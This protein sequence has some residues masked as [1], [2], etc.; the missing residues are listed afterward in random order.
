M[1]G[2]KLSST[3]RAEALN[4]LARQGWAEAHGRDAIMKSYHF[5]DFAEAFAWMTR[6]AAEAEKANHHPE[7]SNTYNKVDV[8]L[9]SHD[10][11]GLTTRD[12]QLAKRF[13]EI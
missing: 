7:W 10:A 2:D 4:D 8:T 11:G 12:V 5:K 13:D 9:T 3:A 1:S 6:A